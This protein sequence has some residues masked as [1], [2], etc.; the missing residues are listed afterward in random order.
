MFY[1]I[2]TAQSPFLTVRLNM[3]QVDTVTSQNN[4]KIE[5]KIGFPKKKSEKGNW[6]SMDTSTINFSAL[7]AS[8]ISFG[9]Y[10]QAGTGIE[11]L[12]GEENQSVHNSFNY[13]N[14]IYAW[15]SILIFRITNTSSTTAQQPMY[16]IVPMKYKCFFSTVTIEEVV[17]KSGHVVFIENVVATYTK[18][19]LFINLS[20][21]NETGIAVE[22]SLYKDWVTN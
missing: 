14:I 3:D 9:D 18:E 13:G 17:F 6:F 5:M 2:G 11:V 22:K 12:S 21:K 7:K 4:F 15:E 16:V 19:R 10:R 20:L 1:L 8:E